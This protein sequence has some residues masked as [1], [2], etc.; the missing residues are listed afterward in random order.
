MLRIRPRG[1]VL[2]AVTCLL[3]GLAVVSQPASAATYTEGADISWPNCPKGLGIPERPTLGLPMPVS[4]ARFVVVGLTNGPA[5]TPNPCL[6]S[7]LAWARERSMAVGAYAV[8]TY[9]TAAELARYGG[10][11]TRGQRLR[12]VGKA[13][14]RFNLARMKAVG[15]QAP[16]VWVDVE[17]SAGRPWASHRRNNALID[18]VLAGYRAAGVKTGLYSYTYGW[19]E[20]TGGRRESLPT[21]MPAGRSG[22]AEARS[23]CA[24]PSFSGGP[25]LLAQWVDGD[26]DRD[27]TCP[28][29]STA[30]AALFTRAAAPVADPPPVD[31][32]QVDPALWGATSGTAGTVDLV[33]RRSDGGLTYRTWTPASGLLGK[34][35]IGGSVRGTPAIVRTAAGGVEVFARGSDDALWTRSRD[36]QGAWSSWRSLGGELS[37]P[38]SAARSGDA[39]HVFAPGVDHDLLHTSSTEPGTWSAWESLGGSLATGTGP[40]AVSPV[41]GHLEVVTKGR[42]GQA[43]RLSYADGWQPWEGL[44][45]TLRGSPAVAS[46]AGELTVVVRRRGGSAY[47]RTATS[48]W[49]RLP[50]ELSS[51]P[52]AAAAPLSGRLDVFG[53]A[54]DGRLSR[55]TRT[56][57]Q[58][59]RWQ[60]VS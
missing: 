32:R 19:N 10:S 56:G 18:G 38:P 9:P 59:R 40:A 47:A 3:G 34:V 12:R 48:G 13:Q 21:W 37:G 4:T 27:V 29:V 26:R 49:E 17:P 36:P 24:G 14:V 50:A 25:V 8:T 57:M 54:A 23:R 5:F 39:L 15:L 52:A 58:W 46:A 55:L 7:Q 45:G 60:P 6:P 35:R 28:G 33:K 31:A 53:T 30:D 16:L 22:Q 11:G 2:A 42:D 1:V 51:P 20:I 44:G 41:E 43:W